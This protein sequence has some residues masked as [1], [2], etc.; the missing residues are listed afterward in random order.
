MT[1]ERDLVGR[2]GRKR[3]FN[4][5]KKAWVKF[6]VVETGGAGWVPGGN[7]TVNVYGVESFHHIPSNSRT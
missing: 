5:N 2:G 3:P 1:L 4:T 7:D 6:D